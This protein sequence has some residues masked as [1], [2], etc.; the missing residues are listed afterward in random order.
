MKDI[1]WRWY[2]LGSIHSAVSVPNPLCNLLAGKL[3]EMTASSMIASIF[4]A[5]P[6]GF[7]LSD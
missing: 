4:A 5:K 3:H 6:Q 7:N 2:K 1:R